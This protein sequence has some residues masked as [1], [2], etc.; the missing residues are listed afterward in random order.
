[1]NSYVYVQDLVEVWRW[2][3]LP[4]SIEVAHIDELIVKPHPRIGNTVLGPLPHVRQVTKVLIAPLVKLTEARPG[5]A[6]TVQLDRGNSKANKASE[7]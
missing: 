1:M 7:H 6:L 4:D 2:F 5:S 3:R